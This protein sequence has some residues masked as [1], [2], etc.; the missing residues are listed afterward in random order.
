MTIIER[1]LRDLRAT[2]D[3]DAWHGTPLRRMFD[4]VGDARA[5]EHPIAGAHSIKEL[6]AH[7]VSWNEIVERRTGGEAYE[8]PADVDFPS[9]DGVAMDSLLA[10][11]DTAYDRLLARVATF[12]DEDLDAIVPGKPYTLDFMLHGLIHHNTY[13][14]AQVAMLKKLV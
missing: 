14:S 12:R 3:G 1:I 9:V 6:L 7:I 10:R 13:H 2:Y 11:L 8:P 4:G 5:N